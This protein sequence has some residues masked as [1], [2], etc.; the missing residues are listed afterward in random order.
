MANVA[1]YNRKLN[2]LLK[3]HGLIDE[4][5]LQTLHEKAAKESLL[6]A[7]LLVTPCLL[8]RLDFSTGIPEACRSMVVVPTIHAPMPKLAAVVSN[9]SLSCL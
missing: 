6:L 5:A 7:T 4:A 9:N 1:G 2:A 3:K 8:P